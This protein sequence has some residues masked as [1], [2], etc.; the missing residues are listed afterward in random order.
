M[1]REMLFREAVLAFMGVTDKTPEEEA[2]S[3]YCKAC[4]KAKPD[5]DCSTCPQNIHID[6]STKPV[7]E[8]TIGD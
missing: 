5:V 1:A 2:V 4:K 6:E 7:K 3:V 8:R